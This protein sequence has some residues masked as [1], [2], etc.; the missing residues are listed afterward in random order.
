MTDNTQHL[1]DTEDIDDSESDEEPQKEERKRAA[2]LAF[3]LG[4]TRSTLFR[5]LDGRCYGSILRGLHTENWRLKDTRFRRWLQ[6]QYQREFDRAVPPQA[7]TSAIENLESYALEEGDEHE[8]FVRTGSVDPQCYYLDLCDEEWRAVEITHDGWQLVDEPGCKFRRASGMMALPEPQGG[9]SVQALR[10]FINCTEDDFVL[11]ASWLLAALRPIGPY[12]V[13]ALSGVQ[14]S[15]KSTCAKIVRS[16]ID[17]SQA[18]IRTAPREERDLLISAINSHCLCYDNIS[19]IPD[20]LSDAFCRISTGGGYA[21][22]TL[23]TDTEETIFSAV[24]PIVLNGIT[25]FLERP[26]LAERALMIDLQRVKRYRKEST[27]MAAV[28]GVRPVV[29]GALLDAMVIGLRNQRTVKLTHP[30]RLADFAEWIVAAEPAL[31]WVPDKFISLYNSNQDHLT[32]DVLESDPAA[33]A[34]L[35]LMKV[36]TDWIGTA[37]QLH[38]ELCTLASD[39]VQRSKEWP[40]SPKALGHRVSRLT[41]ALTMVNIE[42]ERIQRGRSGDAQ[43]LIEVR[44]ITSETS[45]TSDAYTTNGLAPTISPTMSDVP[46]MSDDV[47]PDE[48]NGIVGDDA[49]KTALSDNSYNSDNLPRPEHD[50]P[51]Q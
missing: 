14:G 41:P 28:D 9:G 35:A 26:D 30:P 19:R 31:P 32:R 12:P 51:G 16:L 15:A 20:W 37:T 34:I 33:A 13:L 48:W 4:K 43:R 6:F 27:I 11:I 29:L 50:Y 38:N 45:E 47:G 44:K 10:P 40:K 24:R 7:L 1:L 3:D 8:V 18:L 39:A 42:I 17:P 25:N 22:R 36:R 2:D 5:D 21:A 49:Q 46:T 23:Y